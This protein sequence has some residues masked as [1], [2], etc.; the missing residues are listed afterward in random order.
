MVKNNGMVRHVSHRFIVSLYH[1]I[2]HHLDA[3]SNEFILCISKK[4]FKLG[5]IST[6]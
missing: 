4:S 2:F 6:L 5:K 3:K 1:E